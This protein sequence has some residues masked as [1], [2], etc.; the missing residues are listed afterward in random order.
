MTGRGQLILGAAA[1]ILLT[2]LSLVAA[3]LVGSLV[4]PGGTG[5]LSRTR[6]LAPNLSGQLVSVSLTNMGGPMVVRPN[7]IMGGAMRMTADRST[8]AH[9]TVSFL[10]TNG[11]TISHELVILPLPDNQIPGT[12]PIGGDAKI[13]ETGSLGEASNTCAEGTGQGILP[14]ASGWVTVTLAPGHYELVCNLP[15]HYA[16]GMYTQLTVN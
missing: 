16:A 3:G 12:R 11:G 13:D 1:V 9:G 7:P 2:A 14:G 6:C 5:F 4:N 15:G 10:V 8:V